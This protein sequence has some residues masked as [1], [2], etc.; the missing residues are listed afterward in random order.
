LKGTQ[1]HVLCLVKFNPIHRI[2]GTSAFVTGPRSVFTVTTS[3][4]TLVAS[5]KMS[6]LATE[7]TLAWSFVSSVVVPTSKS[8]DGRMGSPRRVLPSVETKRMRRSQ[9]GMLMSGKKRLI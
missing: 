3:S 6:S 2:I 7:M 5:S 4:V 9:E 1:G 8:G